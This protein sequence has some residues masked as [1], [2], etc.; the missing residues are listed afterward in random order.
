GEDFDDK[1]GYG[2]INSYWAVNN[3]QDLKIIIG[4][5]KDDKIDIVKEKA[6]SLKGG[7]FIFEDIPAGQY[8]VIAWIDV[9]KDGR[10]GPGDYYGE[11][12]F[13]NFVKGEKYKF[14][15][16]IEEVGFDVI[17]MEFNKNLISA[18]D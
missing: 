15:G 13:I 11:S 14:T 6:I 10:I 1:H 3:V 12:N 8:Q 18:I 17:G 16:E 5:R 4:E 9:N 2:L 7:D